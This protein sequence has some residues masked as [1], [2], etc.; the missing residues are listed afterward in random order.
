ML[1][2]LRFFNFTFEINS[3]N[4]DL[5]HVGSFAGKRKKEIRKRQ[6]AEK[7]RN[8]EKKEPKRAEQKEMEVFWVEQREGQTETRILKEKQQIQIS[9]FCSIL[10]L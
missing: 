7:A 9:G 8:K 5:S 2:L 3:H 4:V 6:R 1:N 10:F